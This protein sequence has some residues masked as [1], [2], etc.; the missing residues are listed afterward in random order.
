MKLANIDMPNTKIG[1]ELGINDTTVG[2]IITNDLPKLPDIDEEMGK[3]LHWDIEIM[4]TIQAKKKAR[5]I[6]EERVR[7]N[8]LDNWENTAFKRS[9]LIQGKSTEN[10]KVVIE[11]SI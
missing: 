8:D 9:Q 7:D 10:N 5:L 4:A 1:E 3:L 6:E 2:D 11:W